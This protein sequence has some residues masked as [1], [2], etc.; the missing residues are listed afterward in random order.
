MK[1]SRQAYLVAG[2]ILATVVCLAT[3]L[4]AAPGPSARLVRVEASV[5]EGAVRIEA[6][7]SAP[8]DFTTYR[9]SDSLF[10]VDMA[11][12]VPG[13]AARPRPEV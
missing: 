8:F 6:K 10:I 4:V 13:D 7:A 2:L 9:P 3:P 1:N 11:G 5:S 12:V